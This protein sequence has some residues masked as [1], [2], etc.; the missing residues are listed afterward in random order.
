MKGPGRRHLLLGGAL[1]AVPAA[2]RAQGGWPAER[3]ISFVVP[4]PPGGGT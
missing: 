3:P 2:V 4:F 1:A